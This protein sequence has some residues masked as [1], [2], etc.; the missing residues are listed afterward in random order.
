[1]LNIHYTHLYTLKIDVPEL[2]WNSK[3]GIESLT[4][5]FM[6]DLSLPHLISSGWNKDN[7]VLIDFVH[8]KPC[9]FKTNNQ[10]NYG[11]NGQRH[12]SPIVGYGWCEFQKMK[13]N[14]YYITNTYITSYLLSLKLNHT[15]V[16]KVSTDIDMMFSNLLNPLFFHF[17]DFLDDI[18]QTLFEYIDT[19]IDYTMSFSCLSW[20]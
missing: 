5:G 19:F 18:S 4:L 10:W 6:T 9:P 15:H 16:R 14:N 2:A 8:L 1:M 13:Y 20:V 11:Q 17:F 7:G 3:H 12:F